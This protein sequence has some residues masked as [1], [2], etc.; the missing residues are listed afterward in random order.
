M[1]ATS[2][3][4]EA[5]L[6][7]PGC[8]K[9]TVSLATDA[10]DLRAVQRL[11]YEVFNLELGEGLVESH[12]SGLDADEFDEVCDHLL[13]REVESGSVVGTYRLQSGRSA[14][15]QLGYYSA[16]EFDFAP[17]EPHRADILELGR[18]CVA[19]AHRSSTVLT[20]LWKGIAA[21]ARRQGL[22]YLVGCSSLTSQ[23][24]GVGMAVFRLLAGAHLA[25]AGWRTRPLPAWEC[26]ENG[27]A[28][29][30]P[31]PR[32]MAAYLALGAR[33]CGEPAL[34]RDFKTIDFLTWLDLNALAPPVLRKFFPEGPG[35]V[36]S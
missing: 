16:R 8:G 5:D 20:L 6:A 23:D 25:P 21:C 31:I 30:I 27:P 36:E 3:L 17:F 34:D 32:L 7:P 26:R 15:Q 13:V 35:R 9:Y 10:E 28:S 29:S 1:S 12:E 11:R 24:P 2:V 33:V 14:G 18:A 19:K 4:R 22:R